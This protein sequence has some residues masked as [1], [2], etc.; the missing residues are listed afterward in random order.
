MEPLSLKK[1]NTR[2]EGT[3]EPSRKER[4]REE[5]GHEHSAHGGE[6]EGEHLPDE[7]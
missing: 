1:D 4:E 7:G 5:W 6:G 3:L 2:S